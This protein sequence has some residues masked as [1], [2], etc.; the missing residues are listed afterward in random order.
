MT[1]M[2][3]TDGAV[4]ALDAV[5]GKRDQSIALSFCNVGRVLES[6]NRG[7]DHRDQIERR[8]TENPLAQGNGWKPC[9]IALPLV[10]R[11]RLVLGGNPPSDRAQIAP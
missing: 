2:I 11:A 7:A 1:E 6:G 5:Q 10:S 9:P 3:R 8:I 4:P